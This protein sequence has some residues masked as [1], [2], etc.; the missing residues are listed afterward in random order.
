[1]ELEKDNLEEIKTT[2]E[3]TKTRVNHKRITVIILIVG[4]IL[5]AILC[6]IGLIKQI[7]SKKINQ[8]RHD[9]AIERS[10][11]AVDNAVEKIKDIDEELEYLRKEYTQKRTEF[12]NLNMSDSSYVMK[13]SALLRE[14]SYTHNRINYLETE[15]DR[16]E[17]ANYTEYYYLVEPITYFIFYY[18]AAGVFTLTLIVALI[19]FLVTR[20]NNEVQA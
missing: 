6:G 1:M 19:Y 16:I 5:A 3:K 17:N 11:A 18:I 9:Q 7:N 10:Q 20:K 13:S 14:I 4:I 15:K 2:E 12:S 8:E